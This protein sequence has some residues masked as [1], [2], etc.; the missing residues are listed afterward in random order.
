MIGAGIGSVRTIACLISSEL[1]FSRLGFQFV[2]ALA[3][4]SSHSSSTR[5][6]FLYLDQQP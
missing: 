6:P 5:L 2:L 3:D 1:K 4:V